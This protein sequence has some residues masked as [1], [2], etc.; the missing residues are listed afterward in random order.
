MMDVLAAW[1]LGFAAGACGV[2]LYLNF[3]RRGPWA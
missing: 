3:R 1:L 2:L